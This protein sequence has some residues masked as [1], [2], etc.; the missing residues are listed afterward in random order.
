MPLLLANENDSRTG[1]VAATAA[2]VGKVE[3]TSTNKGKE[4]NYE[5]DQGSEAIEGDALQKLLLPEG[6]FPTGPQVNGFGMAYS[7]AVFDGWVNQPSPCCAAASIAGAW[8]VVHQ[9]NRDDSAALT[10]SD[11]LGVLKEILQTQIRTKTKEFERVVGASPDSL[12][13]ELEKKLATEGKELGGKNEAAPG[14]RKYVMALVREI[15]A[16]KVTGAAS[17]LQDSDVSRCEGEEG[18]EDD[19]GGDNDTDKSKGSTTAGGVMQCFS[20]LGCFSAGKHVGSDSV[21]YKLAEAINQDIL[22]QKKRNPA[23]WQRGAVVTESEGED[24]DVDDEDE[25]EDEDVGAPSMP[26]LKPVLAAHS[27][28]GPSKEIEKSMSAQPKSTVATPTPTPIPTPP[29]QPAR[30]TSTAGVHRNSTSSATSTSSDSSSGSGC[31]CQSSGSSGR[32]A[33]PTVRPTV[34]GIRKH[35]NERAAV[36]GG[37]GCVNWKDILWLLLKKVGGMNKLNRKFPSTGAFGN[38]GILRGLKLLASKHGIDVQTN[39]LM[40]ARTRKGTSQCQ[41]ELQ[42]NDSESDR[43]AQFARLRTLLLEPRTAIIFHL[44]NHYALI[45]GVREWRGPDGVVVQQ[46]LTARKGQRPTAWID[47]DEVREIMLNSNTYKMIAVS[48]R[49]QRFSS[50]QRQKTSAGGIAR[51]GSKSDSRSQS[52]MMRF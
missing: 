29:S 45:Y 18:D 8:N 44:S 38:W 42:A 37:G 5:H 26:P 2:Q 21:F 20:K 4:N 50:G 28:G 22:N 30:S 43:A 24:G 33:R 15:V 41:I 6:R 49:S 9:L 16:Q 51:R 1:V 12:I 31:S 13:Q 39:F 25:G 47:F 10:A 36:K 52:P 19:I 7:S 3:H 14:G 11:A 48:S 17:V 23:R 35:N 32:N 40:G 27:S 46:V 34:G